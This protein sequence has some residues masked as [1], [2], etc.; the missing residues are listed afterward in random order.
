[1]T[2]KEMVEKHNSLL[3][4]IDALYETGVTEKRSL[5]SEE[6]RNIVEL[7]AEALVLKEKI[8]SA[9]AEARS[10][11][12]VVEEEKEERGKETMEMTKELEVRG[13]EQYLRREFDG[14]ELRAMSTTQGAGAGNAGGLIPTYLHGEIV[15]SL[16][17]V[18]PLF[19]L[20]PKLTP[21]A[22]TVRIAKET[23]LENASFVGEG[24]QL[25]PSDP[26]LATIELKQVRAGSAIDI[27]QHLINDAGIDVVSYAQNLLFR[28]LGY[29]LDRAMINGNET[30]NSIQGLVRVKENALG[31]KNTCRVNT[32]RPDVLEIEDLLKMASSMETVYQTGA[33]WI[34]NRAL[35]QQI[36]TMVDLTGKPFMV[37]EVVGDKITYKILGMEVLI[38]D[39]APNIFLVNFEHAYAGMIKKEASLKTVDSDR[40]SA[41]AGTTT[42]VLDTY[43]DAKIVQE[44]AIR[45]LAI[46]GADQA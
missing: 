11:A 18:A 7:R 8:E 42:L 9:K 31:F 30:Q 12:V 16:P 40:Q 39:V 2:I 20:V 37:R 43:I 3:D 36:F 32:A 15:K 5:T 46:S 13:I 25:A 17:E 34:M 26:T 24:V 21:V 14:E 6:E 22:G 45:Y 33:K 27:H 28:R 29:A 41:L 23:N 4:K 38:N 1:M 44:K 35:F 10:G 19:S